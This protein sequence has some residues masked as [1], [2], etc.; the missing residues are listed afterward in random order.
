MEWSNFNSLSLNKAKQKDKPVFIFISSKY[1]KLS[2]KMEE[3]IFNDRKIANTLTTKFIPIRVDRYKESDLFKYYKRVYKLINRKETNEPICIFAT[4]TLE[5]F[6]AFGYIPKETK[7]NT[8]GFMELLESVLEKYKN[9]KET[10]IEHGKEIIE[11]LNRKKNRVKA[12]KFDLKILEKTINNHIENLFDR[13]YGGFGE[14]IKFLNSSVLDLMLCL[15]KNTKEKA[16]FTLKKMGEGGIF[17]RKDKKFYR[18]GLFNW[19]YATAETLEYQ[20][21]QMAK[22]YTRAYLLT[23]DEFYKKMAEDILDNI[24]PVEITSLDSMIADSLIAGTILNSKYF[25]RGEEIAD[26]ILKDRFKN[27]QL[28]HTQNIKGFLE[29][30]AR[31]ATMLLNIY[32]I[33]RNEEYLVFAQNIINIAIEKFYDKGRWYYSLERV[34]IYEDIYDIDYPSPIATILEV[35]L[36]I[37]EFIKEDYTPIISRTLQLHSY[38]LMRQPLSFPNTTKVLILYLKKEKRC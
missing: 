33:E 18:Y 21:S 13:E 15:N 4:S 3:E 8:L 35:M 36:D 30:Y 25:N 7:D 10:L 2:K 6:Y 34:T 14:E 12:T 5:P 9:S 29:D 27:R 1:S 26:N 31:V 37:M 23:K 19:E 32:K 22:L 16:L 20:N 24:T 38:N 28:Y 17:N 11:H